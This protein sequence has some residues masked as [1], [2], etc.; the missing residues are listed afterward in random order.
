[1]AE[2]KIA[3]LCNNE[4]EWEKYPA[5]VFYW[6]VIHSLWKNIFL[7]PKHVVHLRN[8]IVK[9]ST[10]LQSYWRFTYHQDTYN[11]CLCDPYESFDLTSFFN[12]LC[13]YDFSVKVNYS[14]AVIL[15]KGD[16]SLHHC[17]NILTLTNI[18]MLSWIQL[19]K[20][21]LKQIF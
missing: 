16:E 20:F 15:K 4:K 9:L 19:L 11:Y 14:C 3:S 5:A 21:Q 18:S 2:W 6:D 17:L 1:M 13:S 12:V 10:A 8:Y 7:D